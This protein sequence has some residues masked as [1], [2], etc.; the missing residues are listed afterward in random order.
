V[1]VL[2]AGSFNTFVHALRFSTLCKHVDHVVGYVTF[3]Q[4]PPFQLSSLYWPY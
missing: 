1:D 4:L 3:I 2:W